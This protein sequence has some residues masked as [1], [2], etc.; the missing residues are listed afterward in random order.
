MTELLIEIGTETMVGLIA[1][2]AV[3]N[4]TKSN[5][6]NFAILFT[7]KPKCS[8]IYKLSLID[9]DSYRVNSLARQFLTNSAPNNLMVCL[10]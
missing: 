1:G 10:N 3:K 2:A 4:V 5:S 6:L 8:L 7:V 9:R